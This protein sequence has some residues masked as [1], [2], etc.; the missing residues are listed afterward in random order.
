MRI[1]IVFLVF[2]LL[3]SRAFADTYRLENLE[4]NALKVT[5]EGDF[6]DV[7]NSLFNFIEFVTLDPNF[8]A[9][10]ISD[11]Q[12]QGEGYKTWKW[13]KDPEAIDGEAY[14]FELTVDGKKNQLTK[15]DTSE[16]NV[17]QLIIKGPVALQLLRGMWLMSMDYPENF[18]IHH[19][20]TQFAIIEIQDLFSN[21]VSCKK[22]YESS[23]G[24]VVELTASCTL[25]ATLKAKRTRK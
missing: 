21:N 14:V 13:V 10:A 4:E 25:T 19:S 12:Y 8:P 16:I 2:V 22:Y 15:N 23:E 7:T 20:E 1:K 11:G 5:L 6:G 17:K 24:N 18:T 9:D 3:S